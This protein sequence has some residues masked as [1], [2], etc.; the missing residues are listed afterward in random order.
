MSPRSCQSGQG[1]TQYYDII[2]APFHSDYD[3][4]F[5]YFCDH[6]KRTEV[7]VLANAELRHT[8]ICL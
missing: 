6:M 8:I 1:S 4:Y 3:V 5:A 2:I 7:K